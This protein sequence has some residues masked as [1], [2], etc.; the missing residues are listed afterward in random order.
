MNQQSDRTIQ[1]VTTALA[2]AEVLVAAKRFFVRR[3]SIYSAFIEQESATHISLRGM[4]GE[5]LVIGVVRAEDGTRVTGSTYLY[6]Q[7]IARF[8]ATLP[9]PVQSAG[10]VAAVASPATGSGAAVPAESA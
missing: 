3:A 2:P 4:G 8:F 5:E 10:A 9:R 7:Q 1:E 6:D